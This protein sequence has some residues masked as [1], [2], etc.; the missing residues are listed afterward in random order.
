MDSGMG[1][2]EAF[3]T[4]QISSLSCMGETCLLHI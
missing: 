4:S 2:V 3:E 1:R